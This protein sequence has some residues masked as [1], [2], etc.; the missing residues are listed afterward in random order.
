[1]TYDQDPPRLRLSGD[2]SDPFVRALEDARG[3]L[4]GD[5]QLQALAD[6]L[7][8]FEAPP[9]SF[10]SMARSRLRAKS[11]QA[12]AI[13]LAAAVGV[14]A[15]VV[16][17]NALPA[18][19]P[20]AA[21][22]SEARPDVPAAS[23]PAKPPRVAP[24]APV[25]EPESV[26]PAPVEAPRTPGPSVGRTHGLGAAQSVPRH[27]VLPS[28]GDLPASDVD[29][30]ATPEAET[31]LLGRA[32][33]ALASDPARALAL[34]AEHRREYPSGLLQQESDLIAIEA[35]EALGRHEEARTS[36]ARFRARYPSSAH[37]RRLDRL[38]GEAD[39]SVS[40]LGH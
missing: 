23:P 26:A 25:Q 5:E 35:L 32:H 31:A 6:R 30:P 4:P 12:A 3:E 11:M 7:P 18:A 29:G 2:P 19:A 16:I 22:P 10:I 1:M 24:P 36:A 8:I 34:T 28:Q 40:P 21:S 27:D 37:L 15:A 17:K 33:Q 38:F 20:P 9:A 39:V 13:A 14:S